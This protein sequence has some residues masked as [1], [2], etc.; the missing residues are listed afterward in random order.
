MGALSDA[1]KFLARIERAIEQGEHELKWPLWIAFIASYA[2]PFTKND[3]MGAISPKAI[4]A[5]LKDLH[6]AFMKARNLLYGHTDPVETLMDGGQANQ[7]YVRKSAG[8]CEIIPFT[9]VP[10][11]DELPRAKALVRCALD[12]L[13]QRTKS[14]KEHLMAQLI[15]RPDGDYSFPYPNLPADKAPERPGD[16]TPWTTNLFLSR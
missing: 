6:G 9:L 13:T 11:D 7:I 15:D 3:D 1:E 16:A 10:A 2:R 12:D 8:G 4:P 14:G 5:H